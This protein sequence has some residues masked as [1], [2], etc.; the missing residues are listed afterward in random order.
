M[1]RRQVVTTRQGRRFVSVIPRGILERQR[2]GRTSRSL[3]ARARA[4]V[5]FDADRTHTDLGPEAPS[6]GTLIPGTR[7]GLL[8]VCKPVSLAHYHSSPASLGS[9]ARLRC[10]PRGHIIRAHLP[11][12]RARFRLHVFKQGDSDFSTEH[13]RVSS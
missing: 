11:T 9:E 13:D 6:P 5:P 4:W 7:A 8:L 3:R 10:L 12:N 1:S 2:L